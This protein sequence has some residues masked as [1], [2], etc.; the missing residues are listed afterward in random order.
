MQSIWKYALST[1]W[2]LKFK[3][4]KGGIVR[5]V[6]EQRNKICIWVEVEP[7]NKLENREFHIVGTGHN[8]PKGIGGLEYLGTCKLDDGAYVFHV[9]EV[10]S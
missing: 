9:Y 10:K 5:H 3:I 7:E 8:F 4:P 6:D 1:P 2:D